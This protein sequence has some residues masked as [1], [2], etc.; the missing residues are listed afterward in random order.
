MSFGIPENTLDL[1]TVLW[2]S[3]NTI[4]SKLEHS[5]LCQNPADILQND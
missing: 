2:K 4:Q 5:I 1:Y 3:K